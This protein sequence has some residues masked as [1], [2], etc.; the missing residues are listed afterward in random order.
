MVTISYGQP[1]QSTTMRRTQLRQ[2][3]CFDCVCRRCCDPTECGTYVG[4]LVCPRCKAAK[5]ISNNPLDPATE[6]RCEQCNYQISAPHVS[7]VLNRLQFE[8]ENLPKSSPYDLELFL[9]KYCLRRNGANG[10]ILLHANNT[11]VLQIKYALTQLYGN[12]SGFL[13]SGT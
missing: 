1:L 9:E 12:V 3:K 6:W 4:S 11:F 5:M 2:N 10:E 7:L 8:I 13:L